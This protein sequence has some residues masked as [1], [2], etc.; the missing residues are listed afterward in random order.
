VLPGL[1]GEEP[2]VRF[3]LIPTTSPSPS[4]SKES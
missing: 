4:A 2:N 3:T 1:D